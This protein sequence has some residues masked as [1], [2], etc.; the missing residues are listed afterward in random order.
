VMDFNE[1]CT[2]FGGTIFPED[3]RGDYVN[4]KDVIEDMMMSALA[5]SEELAAAELSSAVLAIHTGHYSSAT[6]IL[7][8]ILG[9]VREGSLPRRWEYRAK[10]YLILNSTY[11]T[12][13]PFMRSMSC[14]F[15]PLEMCS[16]NAEQKI[17]D[18]IKAQCDTFRDS[19]TP[20]DRLE[21]DVM[22]GASIIIA[23]ATEK[24][25]NIVP[26]SIPKLHS[27]ASLDEDFK[28][29]IPD[30]HFDLGDL[31][32]EAERMGLEL[33]SRYLD[34]LKIEVCRSCSLTNYALWNWY[35]H[36]ECE[37]ASDNIGLALCKE[38]YADD[39]L[40][41]PNSTPFHF[42]FELYGTSDYDIL[43]WS[44]WTPKRPS[45]RPVASDELTAYL[46]PEDKPFFDVIDQQYILENDITPR[47]KDFSI[48]HM[49]CRSALTLYLDARRIMRDAGSRRGA[50]T[51]TLKIFCLFYMMSIRRSYMWARTDVYTSLL[52]HLLS[53][54]K[55]EIQASG[56]TLLEKLILPYEYMLQMQ[57]DHDGQLRSETAYYEKASDYVLWAEENK[58]HMFLRS[59]T[60]LAQRCGFHFQ[61]SCSRFAE[62][63]FSFEFARALCENFE[64]HVTHWF[65]A[66]EAVCKLFLS[67]DEYQV[68][69]MILD[70]LMVIATPL[71]QRLQEALSG[72]PST[73]SMVEMRHDFI[74]RLLRLFIDTYSLCTT[75]VLSDGLGL[76]DLL[77]SYS[78]TEIQ[79]KRTTSLHELLDFMSRRHQWTA[80]LE[81]GQEDVK[82]FMTREALDLMRCADLIED[83][84][85]YDSGF[86]YDRLS[87][88][89][90]LI[91]VSMEATPVA[92]SLAAKWTSQAM[93][94][95]KDHELL[96]WDQREDGMLAKWQGLQTRE[97][98]AKLDR[99]L[100]N[101][102]ASKLELALRLCIE[103]SLWQIV[104]ILSM[105]IADLLPFYP[106]SVSCPTG[107]WPWQRRL[108][109]GL[110][111]EH[112]GNHEAAL[113]MYMQST[114][115]LV[116]LTAARHFHPRVII[117]ANPDITRVWAGVARMCCYI[118]SGLLKLR[119]ARP[120]DDRSRPSSDSKGYK[121]DAIMGDHQRSLFQLYGPSLHPMYR[122]YAEQIPIDCAHELAL[123]ILDS[124][125]ARHVFEQTALDMASKK[126][127]ETEK[128]LSAYFSP[129]TFFR[130]EVGSYLETRD[131]DRAPKKIKANYH[132]DAEFLLYTTE[133]YMKAMN[134][135]PKPCDAQGMI[136]SIGPNT[137][138]VHTSLSKDGLALFCISNAGIQ[139]TIWDSNVDEY[140]VAK[141]VS[142]YLG[143]IKKFKN[144]APEGRLRGISHC[145]SS[146]IITPV[147][148]YLRGHNKIMFVPSGALARFPLSSLELDDMPLVLQKVVW[149]IPSLTLQCQL[150]DRGLSISNDKRIISS[151]ARVASV[152]D[153]LKPCAEPN[154]PMAGIE[155][156][157]IARA[158]GD[159][160]DEFR[161][162]LNAAKLTRKQFISE[163]EKSLIIHISTHGYF[164]P[165]KPEESYISLKEPF[166]IPDLT[167]VWTD[168]AAVVFSSCLSGSGMPY[169]NDDLWGF[170]HSVLSIGVRLFGGCLWAVNDLTTL[171]HSFYFYKTFETGRKLGRSFRFV[172]IWY[173]A[174]MSLASTTIKS[175]RVV[176]G[177]IIQCWD[178]MEEAD[179][180]PKS[181]APGGRQRLM[182]A[183]EELVD[184]DGQE[185]IDFRHPYVWGPYSLTGW[186]D[187][188][189]RWGLTADAMKRSQEQVILPKDGPEDQVLRALFYGEREG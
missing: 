11:T 187:W 158:A 39:T 135:Y 50:A 3:R 102:I 10:S 122:I 36:E 38:I 31:Q 32:R 69:T 177:S 22:H 93:R 136:S 125:R 76:V 189:L 167:G 12:Y 176:I 24:I 111:E 96:N 175:A 147:A 33:V 156:L 86:G 47:E 126:L 143:L 124:T 37:E 82:S 71:T 148:Q 132:H 42:G 137:I 26:D 170:A 79:K 164:D 112:R 2:L 9:R 114:Y 129:A 78:I 144:R 140:S 130:P 52:K 154:L 160:S 34:R 104:E 60:M 150:R 180:K 127:S 20:I 98:V 14:Y 92:K 46:C 84:T 15:D 179:L 6:R 58:T 113:H 151:I 149:Q 108:W 119:D 168:A 159:K 44:E 161:P 91:L 117:I 5:D 17:R 1:T 152:R 120:E 61:Y 27:P 115:F 41:G 90:V 94:Y 54:A 165:Y 75:R 56:D 131:E 153:S 109:T 45:V 103:A 8:S 142:E 73:E 110:F 118:H 182:S 105:F 157:F 74:S 28:Q 53:T 146:L 59:L 66:V 138:V 95:M 49:R 64:L 25:S 145:L 87:L 72:S 163:I 99:R 40:C 166:R 116:P 16:V 77:N 178:S 162:P 97:R 186:A 185:L 67:R 21:N 4:L 174:T 88:E 7:D 100:Q 107:T 134:W 68:S 106:T 83:I 128:W 70:S 65:C 139:Q 35:L 141:L 29:C 81:E 101:K 121:Y 123:D 169:P 48:F 51:V 155:A 133:R 57:N 85:L 23:A 19:V 172:D 18:S 171:L 181:F 183:K 173:I 62:A 13:P 43:A 184:R 55:D 80:K 63:V 188:E 89:I 30:I